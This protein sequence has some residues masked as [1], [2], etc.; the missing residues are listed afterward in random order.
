MSWVYI[1]QSINYGTYYVGSTVEIE[2]RL[3]K[4]N[5]GQVK[6]TQSKK[7][8]RL[9]YKEEYNSLGEARKREKHIKSWKERKAIERLIGKLTAPSSSLV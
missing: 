6:S 4:H 9:I 3:R 8:W 7:P 1:L 5:N 2:Q